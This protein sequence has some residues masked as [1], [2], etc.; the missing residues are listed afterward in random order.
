MYVDQRKYAFTERWIAFSNIGSL[1]KN[2]ILEN[3]SISFKH[4]GPGD[5]ISRGGLN[6]SNEAKIRNHTTFLNL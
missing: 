5:E 1:L 4:L 3:G 2:T 6:F